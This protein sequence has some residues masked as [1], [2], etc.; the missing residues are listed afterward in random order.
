MRVQFRS[1]ELD[2]NWLKNIPRHSLAT[3]L[4]L[5]PLR[6]FTLSLTHRHTGSLNL[7]DGN[8]HEI[9]G[10][11]RFGGRVDWSL[12]PA[13]MFLSA[14]NLFDTMASSLGFLS[15][16]PATGQQVPFVYPTGGRAV[17]MGVRVSGS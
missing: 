3:A 11:H 5:W 2:G 14:D 6:T 10:Y 15:F 1:G 12:G 9:P 7:D 13:S 8:T 17:R 16:D 4:R